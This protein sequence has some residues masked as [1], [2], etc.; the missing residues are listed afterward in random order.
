M[1]TP[2]DIHN[3]EFKKGFRGYA[4]EDVDNFM[5]T[6]ATDYEKVYR[7]YS[8]LKE[9]CESLQDKLTQY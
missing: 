9:R 2:M 8:E 3:K 1:L 4:E 6:L 5:E 7:E